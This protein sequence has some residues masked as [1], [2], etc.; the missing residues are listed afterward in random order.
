MKEI[1]RQEKV[2]EAS[3]KLPAEA[4][5]YEIEQLAEADLKR[6]VL[7][8]EATAEAVRVSS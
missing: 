3:V 2:L 7:E 8:A 5:K 6:I 4:S 1:S